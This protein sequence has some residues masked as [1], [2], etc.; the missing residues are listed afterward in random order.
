MAKKSEGEM[1]R[2]EGPRDFALF[3]RNQNDGRFNGECAGELQDLV[4][5]LRKHAEQK[6]GKAKGKL[7][8]TFTLSYLDGAVSVLPDVKQ[9]K[10]PRVR[11]STWMFMTEGDNL[12][13]EQERQTTLALREVKHAEP[14][15][16]PMPEAA[17]PK[18]V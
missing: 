14:K 16:A 11:G 17:A 6:G 2:E 13:L 4:R 3:M 15:Q 1:D 7:T 18:T 10:P 5:A 9:T 12:S 8:V